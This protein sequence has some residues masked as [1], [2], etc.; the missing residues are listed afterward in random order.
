M[1]NSYIKDLEARIRRDLQR[2]LNEEPSDY[3]TGVVDAITYVLDLVCHYSEKED[4][5]NGI[6]VSFAEATLPDPIEAEIESFEKKT[7]WRRP[8]SH[9]WRKEAN[10]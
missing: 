5:D 4:A 9:K 6:V 7:I 2:E 1:K 10:G 3:Q 8:S